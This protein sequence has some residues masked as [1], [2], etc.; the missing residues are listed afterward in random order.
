M[1]Q[2]FLE[3]LNWIKNIALSRRGNAMRNMVYF[4]IKILTEQTQ[5]MDVKCGIGLNIVTL[6]ILILVRVS[7]QNVG[8]CLAELVLKRI[9]FS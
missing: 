9:V 6:S 4:R 3:S 2:L 1:G 7:V 5:R 8:L